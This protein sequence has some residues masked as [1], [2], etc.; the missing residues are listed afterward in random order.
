M[1][2]LINAW[3]AIK[4]NN[5]KLEPILGNQNNMPEYST[6]GTSGLKSRYPSTAPSINKDPRSRNKKN[7]Q[8]KIAAQ[9]KRTPGDC[10]IKRSDISKKNQLKP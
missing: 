5:N 2:A 9:N 4:I 7:N 10:V 1:A 6:K 8:V 3:V